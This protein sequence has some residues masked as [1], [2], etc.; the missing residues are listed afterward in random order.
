MFNQNL[1]KAKI[2]EKN[3][4]VIELCNEL[5]ICEATFY[6]KLSRNGD[7]SRFEIK[8]ISKALKLTRDERD[9]I[10]FLLQNLRKRKNKNKI[11]RWN[12][13]MI[14]YDIA[15]ILSIVAVVLSIITNIRNRL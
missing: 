11:K 5:G 15:L 2:I 1:L 14:K 13:E 9:K 7:F 6:R 4:S 8:Q 12:C 10:F 3:I